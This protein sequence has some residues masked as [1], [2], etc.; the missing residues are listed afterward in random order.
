MTQNKERIGIQTLS[1]DRIS[2]LQEPCNKSKLTNQRVNFIHLQSMGMKRSVV[3]TPHKGTKVSNIPWGKKKEG[4]L[5]GPE[6]AE[7]STRKLGQQ[8]VSNQVA[9]S[10]NVPKTESQNGEFKQRRRVRP[11]AQGKS[12]QGLIPYPEEFGGGTIKLS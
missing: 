7:H 10:G 12:N 3:I 2:T 11:W 6:K 4:K 1:G 9:S 5:R 8:G